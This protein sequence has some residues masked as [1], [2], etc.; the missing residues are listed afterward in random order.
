MK[1]LKIPPESQR[2][3]SD[4]LAQLRTPMTRIKTTLIA[5]IDEQNGV[6]RDAP[7]AVQ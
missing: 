7:A 1:E 3:Y 4:Q 2:A 5:I 6:H